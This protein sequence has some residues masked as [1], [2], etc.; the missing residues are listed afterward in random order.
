MLAVNVEETITSICTFISEYC[1]NAKKSKLV[2]GLS[3]G[4]DSSVVAKLGVMA[5]GK[6]NIMPL[7]L[8]D[9]STPLEDFEHARLIAKTLDI[10]LK[11][12]D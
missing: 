7:F 6:D 8:P 2:I 5:L 11:T 12:I 4:I 10:P 3:G 1:V 9:I